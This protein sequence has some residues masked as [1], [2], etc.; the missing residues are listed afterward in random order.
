MIDEKDAPPDDASATLLSGAGSSKKDKAGKK[1]GGAVRPV[2]PPKK[3]KDGWPRPWPHGGG[4][5]GNPSPSPADQLHGIFKAA[6]EQLFTAPLPVTADIPDFFFMLPHRSI[7]TWKQG[8]LDGQS[9]L[10]VANGHV[11]GLGTVAPFFASGDGPPV[12]FELFDNEGKRVSA[13]VHWKLLTEDGRPTTNL[14]EYGT[15]DPSTGRWQAPKKAAANSL[16]GQVVGE[17]SSPNLYACALILLP[18]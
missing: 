8:G 11:G 1:G 5:G 6:V 15:L 9:G 13:G 2:K 12:D 18:G 16:I 14:P 10:L 4:G 17:K 7:L 3:R